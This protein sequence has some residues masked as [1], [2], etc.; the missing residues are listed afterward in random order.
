MLPA[1]SPR[2]LQLSIAVALI[3]AAMP[4][5]WLRDPRQYRTDPPTSAD[6]GKIRLMPIGISGTPPEIYF[7]MGK[8]Y[9]NDSYHVSQGK[10]LYD[11]FGCRA[12]HGDGR[13]ADGPSFL[14]GWWLY[15]PEMIS[16]VA[17]IRKGRPHGMP[18]FRNKMTDEQIWQ[19]A[20]YVQSIGAYQA[21]LSAP[22]RNDDKHT[23]PS[24]NRAPATLN[25]IQGPVGG[26]RNQGP[27]P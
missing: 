7:A 3:A 5:G 23:R 27:T 24:E 11:W 4:L 8:P 25:F 26:D 19:L 10:R 9:Q 13:G 18:P 15:G 21:H 16:I 6:L 1:F 17:S 2:W 12:C 20:A 14:D 22:S